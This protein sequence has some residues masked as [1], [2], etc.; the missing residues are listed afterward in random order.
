MVGPKFADIRILQADPWQQLYDAMA[1]A[2]QDGNIAKFRIAVSLILT[3]IPEKSKELV[4]SFRIAASLAITSF[5]NPEDFAAQMEQVL[6]KIGKTEKKTENKNDFYE[7]KKKEY[8][9]KEKKTE[10]K[11]EKVEK[12]ANEKIVAV[13]KDIGAYFL[14]GSTLPS[15]FYGQSSSEDQPSWSIGLLREYDDAIRTGSDRVKLKEYLRAAYGDNDKLDMLLS[16]VEN[17][18]FLNGVRLLN[19]TQKA[20]DGLNLAFQSASGLATITEADLSRLFGDAI[21]SGQQDGIL[22]IAGLRKKGADFDGRDAVSGI[23]DA[24]RKFAS[25]NSLPIELVNLVFEANYGEGAKTLAKLTNSIDYDTDGMLMRPEA[26]YRDLAG[27]IGKPYFQKDLD[28]MKRTLPQTFNELASRHLVGADI[29]RGRHDMAEIMSFREFYKYA[30]SEM[31][32]LLDDSYTADMVKSMAGFGGTPLSPAVSC[33]ILQNPGTIKGLYTLHPEKQDFMAAFNAMVNGVS[34]IYSRP[35]GKQLPMGSRYDSANGLVKD[36]GGIKGSNLMEDLAA[37]YLDLTFNGKDDIIKLRSIYSIML[38]GGREDDINPIR[39]IFR[40]LGMDPKS[41]KDPE[42]WNQAVMKFVN[43]WPLSR[44]LTLKEKNLFY[45]QLRKLPS[46]TVYAINQLVE[47]YLTYEWSGF[48]RLDASGDITGTSLNDIFKDEKHRHGIVDAE[49][50]QMSNGTIGTRIN[51]DTDVY[52]NKQSQTKVESIY[53]Q[54]GLFAQDF[55]MNNLLISNFMLDFISTNKKKTAGDN[56]IF[57]EEIGGIENGEEKQFYQSMVQKMNAYSQFADIYTEAYWYLDEKGNRRLQIHAILSDGEKYFRVANLDES[58]LMNYTDPKSGRTFRELVEVH[59]KYAEI[60]QAK[61]DISTLTAGEYQEQKKPEVGEEYNFGF[62]I[63]AANTKG[64]YRLAGIMAKTPGQ[65]GKGKKSGYA[66]VTSLGKFRAGNPVYVVSAGYLLY[67][68]PNPDVFGQETNQPYKPFGDV[69]QTEKP[70]YFASLMTNYLYAMAMGG[71]DILGGQVRTRHLGGGMVMKF[72]DG[73]VRAFLADGEYL[74]DRVNVRVLAR[75]EE[76]KKLEG[77][78]RVTVDLGKGFTLQ[79][80]GSARGERPGEDMQRDPRMLELISSLND[81]MAEKLKDGK[82]ATG[83]MVRSW[84]TQVFEI[85]RQLNAYSPAD[86]LLD[87]RNGFSVTLDGDIN[88]KGFQT[89]LSFANM[90]MGR[91]I[92]PETGKAENEVGLYM[93][94]MNTL[95]TGTNEYVSFVFGLPVDAPKDNPLPSNLIG[96]KIKAG[97][98]AVALTGYNLFTDKPESWK[99]DIANVG[100]SLN[101]GVTLKDVDNAWSAQVYM[102]NDKVKGTIGTGNI[103][104]MPFYQLAVNYAIGD[105]LR[106]RI[107]LFTQYAKKDEL[108]VFEIGPGYNYNWNGN[109]VGVKLSWI[110]SRLKDASY[111]DFKIEVNAGINF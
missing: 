105:E 89:T 44:Q 102:G 63:G 71:P 45:N 55:Q 36:I 32:E 56:G 33:T 60:F 21:F 108:S 66:A 15:S 51:M 78:V 73:G 80:Y 46:N 96:T 13:A 98:F 58:K 5:S 12:T 104:G 79:L 107:S 84:A 82:P 20:I 16:L 68:K 59:Q 92:N 4:M 67:P 25:D 38:A 7:E 81:E 72:G 39:E 62:V 42:A 75:Q 9:E 43:D 87:Y 14:V 77:S 49:L 69:V 30:G 86:D 19:Y 31:P 10:K 17:D 97:N 53:D 100:S 93:V 61:Y 76:E 37:R 41:Y 54:F 57:L 99:F 85:M 94:N 50:T 95:Q 40:S 110:K 106:H 103:K 70:L 52:D 88:G 23:M 64:D 83:E 8:V 6:G 27:E 3:S 109:N 34:V 91:K 18:S 101:W 90:D 48:Q 28:R 22:K 74:T 26:F 11:T 1:Q 47:K 24:L 65:E 29:Y 111:G 35:I 2:Q